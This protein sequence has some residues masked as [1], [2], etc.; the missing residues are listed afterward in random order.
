MEVSTALTWQRSMQFQPEVRMKISKSSISRALRRAIAERGMIREEDTAVIFY[1]LSW[2]Q[3]RIGEL[4]SLFPAETL[5]AIAVKANPL[6]KVLKEIQKS[7]LGLEAA[8]LP[9]LCLAQKTGVAPDRIVYDS[10]AKSRKELEYALQAGVHINADSLAELARIDELL[11]SMPLTGTIGV[12]INPQVGS[13]SISM[14][15]VAGE[16]SKFGVPIKQQREA[17]LSSF[18]RFDWLKG[19]HLHVGSQGCELELIMR[20]IETVYNFALEANR[21]LE[22]EG[23]ERRIT[24]F[25]IGGGMPV[26]YRPDAKIPAMEEYA[27]LLKS[28]LPGLFDGSFRVITEFGRWL[29]AHSG[30]TASRVEYVKRDDKVN[31]V[32][33]HVGADLLLRRCYRPEEWHHEIAVADRSGR[34][35]R[36]RERKPF[37]IAGPLCFAGDIIAREVTLPPVEEGDYILIQDPGAYTLSMWS[38]YNSR[39]IPR[40]LGYYD[41]GERFELLRERES[42]AQKVEFWG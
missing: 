31:T 15:S 16:Y 3:G 13:G 9:E 42:L 22:R 41:E 14:L 18:L 7:G 4:V 23:K 36:G 20:G 26:A 32:M 12:R 5:H 25:D 11:K 10:P 24:I 30:W 37:T 8:S 6:V 28:R 27:A 1:D 17:L 34:L 29:H 40:V 38:L 35:K 39:Q 2:L 19:V 21:L 33:I